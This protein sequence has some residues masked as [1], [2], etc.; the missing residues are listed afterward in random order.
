MLRTRASAKG[1]WEDR[2]WKLN[3]KPGAQSEAVVKHLAILCIFSILKNIEETWKIK[4]NSDL[5]QIYC[6]R[7][8]KV[9]F[10][11]I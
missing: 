6:Q 5:L 1:P 11:W 7:G 4:D 2:L 9:N 10:N 3:P 8:D